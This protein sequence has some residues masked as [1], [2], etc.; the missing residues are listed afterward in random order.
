[1]REKIFPLRSLLI[2]RGFFF[3]GQLI[4]PSIVTQTQL[5]R[6]RFGFSDTDL[7]ALVQEFLNKRIIRGFFRD[8]FHQDKLSRSAAFL[9]RTFWLKIDGVAHL[10]AEPVTFCV[11][12]AWRQCKSCA[13]A[14][15][16]LGLVSNGPIPK[17][18]GINRQ[19]G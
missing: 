16:G 1:M 18:N 10:L 11:L 15:G 5:A 8:M 13:D 9:S 12:D 14:A 3:F 4:V 2:A 6:K 7:A 17:A 19:C